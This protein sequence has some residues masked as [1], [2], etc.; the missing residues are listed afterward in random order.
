MTQ[1]P[2]TQALDTAVAAL[3]AALDRWHAVVAGVAAE[4]ADV[5]DAVADPRLEDA[6]TAFSDALGTVHGAVGTVL[7]LSGGEEPEEDDEP[8][9][10]DVFFL[11]FFVGL[12]EGSPGSALDEVI[13]L[14]DAG[15]FDV[16]GR[17]E[18]AGFVVPT[19]AASR[20]ELS[21]G[22][23]DEDLGDDSD[24]DSDDDSTDDGRDSADGG[25]DGMGTDGT[26]RDS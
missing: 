17:L 22:L 8:V 9:E 4:A 19:F 2:P 7:G 3:H 15:G 14:I 21:V 5:S 25:V 24:D 10:G 18:R 23:L 16:V 26:G 20:G 13:E 6:E 11:Q 12:P 1:L